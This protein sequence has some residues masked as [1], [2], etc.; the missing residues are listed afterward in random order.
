M[1]CW[2]AL[3]FVLVLIAAFREAGS[4]RYKKIT[5]TGRAQG[6]TYAITYYATDSV[7]TARQ[8]DSILRVIDQ[9][10]SLYQRG[11]LINRFN[12]SKRGIKADQHLLTVVQKGI[13]TFHATGGIFDITLHPLVQAWGFGVKKSEKIPD[14][15][16]LQ[17][18]R[19]CVSGEFI[20]I[21]NNRLKKTKPCV[22]IDLNGIAQGYTV[23]VLADF[24]EKNDVKN[25]LVELGGEIRVK[26]RKLP[27]NEKMK[28]GI[29]SPPQSVFERAGLQQIIELDSG[30]ITTSG[31]YRQFYES[32]GRKIS[33]I[34]DARTGY[35]ADTELISAIV[36]A[37]DAITA[38][39]YDN[40]L[41]AMGLEKAME[42]VEQRNDLAAYFIYRKPDGQVADTACSQFKRLLKR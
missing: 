38:D 32:G 5:I 39:A 18:I 33:H 11:S 15:A 19:Q 13:E 36:F 42:F 29:E 12:H 26:G 3:L 9:S 37:P 34:I 17:S 30:A 10:L 25:Y 4:R 41:M 7:V 14:S 27:G 1:R 35:P 2:Y 22:K 20:Q 8:V 24:L 40:A 21:S 28:I 6:T 16:Y 31:S 23:D